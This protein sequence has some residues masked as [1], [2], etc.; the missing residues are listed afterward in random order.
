MLR[1]LREG[2]ILSVLSDCSDT[3]RLR[4][5]TLAYS[6]TIDGDDA[7]KAEA[8]DMV[9]IGSETGHLELRFRLPNQC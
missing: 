7:T 6:H 4:D 9:F 1:V 8:V 5:G 3:I 2:I